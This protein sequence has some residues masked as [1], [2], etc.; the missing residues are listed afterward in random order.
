MLT[1]V[2]VHPPT[3]GMKNLTQIEFGF[4]DDTT[5]KKKTLLFHRCADIR[6]IMDF[7][8]LADQ[9]IFGREGSIAQVDVSQMR[10]FIRSRRPHWRLECMP[11]MPEDKPSRKKAQVDSELRALPSCLFR[12]HRGNLGEEF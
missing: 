3:L 2:R 5:H 10:E 4:L 7:D 9:C 8:V 12:W 1:F 6:F 11:P